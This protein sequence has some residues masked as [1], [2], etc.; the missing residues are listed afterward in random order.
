MNAA[1]MGP[2]VG[3]SS[4]GELSGT[5]YEEAATV[6]RLVWGLTAGPTMTDPKGMGLCTML[7]H[8]PGEYAAAVTTPILSISVTAAVNLTS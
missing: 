1:C 5:G 4:T 7:Y 3:G 6:G 8:N 2:L